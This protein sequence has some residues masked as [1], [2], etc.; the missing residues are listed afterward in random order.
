MSQLLLG[1]LSWDILD[2]PE[3]EF[4]E[5]GKEKGTHG[6]IYLV[7][8]RMRTAG[9]VSQSIPI[10]TAAIQLKLNKTVHNSSLYRIVRKLPKTTLY[11]NKTWTARKFKR[12]NIAEFNEAIK[13]F[14]V[15]F[16][17]TKNPDLYAFRNPE[18]SD[19]CQNSERTYPEDRAPEGLCTES[20]TASS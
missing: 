3:L 17:I 12:E 7:N 10:I 2:V 16:F 20:Q 9:F 1:G 15:L 19:E 18:A 6:T 11:T 5:I 14:Y 8:D 13:G 4:L